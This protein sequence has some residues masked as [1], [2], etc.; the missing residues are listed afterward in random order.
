MDSNH[1]WEIG[2]P[3]TSTVM[4]TGPH[5]RCWLALAQGLGDLLP[6][7]LCKRVAHNLGVAARLTGVLLFVL[8]QVGSQAGCRH[9]PVQCLLNIGESLHVGA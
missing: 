2:A 7:H 6:V 4:R 5:P 8:V 1:L 9:R 3:K